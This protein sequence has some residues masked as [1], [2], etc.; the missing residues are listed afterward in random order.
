MNCTS[1]PSTDA[2]P[3]TGHCGA[4][5]DRYYASLARGYQAGHPRAVQVGT[6]FGGPVCIEVHERAEHCGCRGGGWHSTE[7]DSWHPCPERGHEGPHPEYPDTD[8]TN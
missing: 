5:D 4:C 7:F 6:A 1:C 3:A 8:F 2:D